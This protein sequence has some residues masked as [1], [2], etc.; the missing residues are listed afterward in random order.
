MKDFLDKTTPN[1][2]TKVLRLLFHIA[3]YG[4]QAVTPHIKKLSSLPLWEIRVL[5]KDSMRILFV[6]RVN[7][8]VIL[9]HAFFKKTQKTPVKE[10]MIALSRLR[11]IEK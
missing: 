4:L 5:G 1:Q 8:R 6:T 9:L 2:K 11:E 7:N 10:I 3:E